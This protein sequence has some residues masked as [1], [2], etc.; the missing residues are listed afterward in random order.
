[1]SAHKE[2]KTDFFGFSNMATCIVFCRCFIDTDA[3]S[4]LHFLKGQFMSDELMN[5]KILGKRIPQILKS[6]RHTRRQKEFIN[7]ID[8]EKVDYND[9]Y[10]KMYRRI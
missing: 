9:L 1:M 6:L 2:P 3:R 5:I 10:R 4:S 8:L 7:K